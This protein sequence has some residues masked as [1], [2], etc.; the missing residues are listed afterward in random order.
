[1]V[2]TLSESMRGTVMSAGVPYL[3]NLGLLKAS[4]RSE[5]IVKF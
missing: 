1:M 5:A 4:I 2:S 3:S